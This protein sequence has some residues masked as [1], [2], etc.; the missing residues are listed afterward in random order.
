MVQNF[1]LHTY[2]SRWRF[3]W[4]H[5]MEWFE[6]LKEAI[7]QIQRTF[8]MK[9][10]WPN[11]NPHCNSSRKLYFQKKNPNSFSCSFLGVDAP[12]K[13]LCVHALEDG[14][15]PAICLARWFA[16]GHRKN[17]PTNWKTSKANFTGN[18]QGLILRIWSQNI[19]LNPVNSQIWQVFSSTNITGT[20][21]HIKWLYSRLH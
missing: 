10:K 16:K 5:E 20:K 6:P 18:L 21:Q 12:Y 11:S 14:A 9:F 4:C 17:L 2:L 13:W 19:C 7:W 3:W 8:L 15:A 1:L